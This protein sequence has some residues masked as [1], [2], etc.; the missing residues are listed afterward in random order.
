MATSL[1][2]RKVKTYCECGVG[3]IHSEVKVLASDIILKRR[4]ELIVVAEK[5]PNHDAVD[6]NCELVAQGKD[7]ALYRSLRPPLLS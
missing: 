6:A 7:Y 1:R 3:S 4:D 5:C 2:N